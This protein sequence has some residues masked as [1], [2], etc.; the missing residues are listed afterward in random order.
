MKKFITLVAVGIGFLAFASLASAQIASSLHN[1]S[2]GGPNGIKGAVDEICVY[3]HTPH[4]GKKAIDPAGDWAPLWNRNYDPTT[5]GA[6][7]VYNSYTVDAARSNPPT[8]VSKACLSCHDGTLGLNQ[9]INWPGRGSGAAFVPNPDSSNQIGTVPPGVNNMALIG[10]DLSDDHPVSMNYADALSYGT[11]GAIGEDTHAAGFRASAGSGNR[12]T[13]VNGTVTLPL[14]GSS[15]ATAKVECGSCH[16]PHEA[17]SFA[18][19]SGTGGS[20]MFLR[21]A[22][23]ASA[24]CITCHLK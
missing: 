23:T 9:L 4:G 19:Q 14:Y 8:G 20:V 12:W 18:A 17:R 13:V 7:T 15:Q 3:C 5:G 16:D 11:G 1:L 22:N 10:R 24:L 21:A 6:F 2:S